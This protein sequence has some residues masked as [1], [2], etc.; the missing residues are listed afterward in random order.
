V[1][2]IG[3]SPFAAK[4]GDIAG[5]LASAKN[6]YAQ[7]LA[8]LNEA[9]SA[10]PVSSAGPVRY[11]RVAADMASCGCLN[12][13]TASTASPDLQAAKAAEAD[14]ASELNKVKMEAR[15]FLESVK[16]GGQLPVDIAIW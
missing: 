11:G 3:Q 12:P 14:A 2:N 16:N 1:G 15:E 4:A 8:K 9:Q 5:R 7:A 10:V 6:A 13:D